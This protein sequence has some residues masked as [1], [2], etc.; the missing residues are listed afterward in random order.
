MPCGQQYAVGVVQ[1]FMAM[2]LHCGASLR[3][4]ASVLELFGSAIG[5]DKFAPNASTGRL[6][7]LRVGL[8][9]LLRDKVIAADDHWPLVSS[10][11]PLGTTSPLLPA[12]QNRLRL[13]AGFRLHSS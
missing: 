13:F 11:W 4:A 8:A 12:H 10:H 7:L 2:V 6:W 3:C 1:R 5:P 9:A